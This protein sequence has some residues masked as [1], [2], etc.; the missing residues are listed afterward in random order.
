MCILFCFGY[1][2]VTAASMGLKGLKACLIRHYSSK[3]II[4]LSIS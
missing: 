2:N 1:A 3:V 4:L